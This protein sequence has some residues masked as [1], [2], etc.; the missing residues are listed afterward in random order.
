MYVCVCV[1]MCVEFLNDLCYTILN[2][3][4]KNGKMCPFYNL[5]SLFFN[6]HPLG[7]DGSNDAPMFPPHVLMESC[8]KCR[9]VIPLVFGLFFV[10][11]DLFVVLSCLKYKS[12]TKPVN[13]TC[14]LMLSLEVFFYYNNMQHF[15][16]HSVAKK[17]Y[18]DF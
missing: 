16:F 8:F 11:F 15:I 10:S 14:L 6:G 5:W 12:K 18:L 1:S 4:I 9:L 17:P 2:S 7:C 13:A 3:F